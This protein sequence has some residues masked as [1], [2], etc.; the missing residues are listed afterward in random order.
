MGTALEKVNMLLKR[1]GCLGLSRQD[2]TFVDSL[3]PSYTMEVDIGSGFG[4]S[5][6]KLLPD[7]GST[8]FWVFDS[9]C[10]SFE[11][12]GRPRLTPLLKPT[13]SLGHTSINYL[14]GTMSGP[15]MIADVVLDPSLAQPLPLPLIAITQV[16]APVISKI[17]NMEGIL[18]LARP[19]AGQEGLCVLSY[20]KDKLPEGK[21]NFRITL[22]RTAP[23]IDFAVT[24]T[25]DMKWSQVCADNHIAPNFWSVRV[26]VPSMKKEYCA[27]LDTGSTDSYVPAAWKAMID[28]SGAAELE[29]VDTNQELSFPATLNGAK[30]KS[31]E[32]IG[33]DVV[34]LGTNF[35][36]T[37]DVLFDLAGDRVTVNP[38]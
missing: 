12:N 3:V 27:I 2:I 8:K 11:C 19:I 25:D 7:T 18:G 23:E 5:T 9:H 28:Q 33:S 14:A 36:G 26:Y 4:S 10:S 1:I 24:P 32:S 31:S 15:A 20:L 34:I 22:A 6:V 16:D 21:K 29:L 38:A 13:V 17:A 35:F 37:Y 30:M